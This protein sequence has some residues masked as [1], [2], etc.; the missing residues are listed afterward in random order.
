MKT[1]YGCLVH[2]ESSYELNNQIKVIYSESE[3][4]TGETEGLADKIK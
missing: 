3:N 4:V 2:S 1:E